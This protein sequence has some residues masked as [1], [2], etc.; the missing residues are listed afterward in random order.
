MTKREYCRARF[1]FLFFFLRYLSFACFYRQVDAFF[2]F[3]RKKIESSIIKILIQ[4]DLI[5]LDSKKN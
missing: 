5:T 3:I 4:S 1:Y 2:D